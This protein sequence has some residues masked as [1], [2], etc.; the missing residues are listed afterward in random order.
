MNYLLVAKACSN[1]SFL[2]RLGA[3]SFWFHR[4]VHITRQT[5]DL[6][7]DAYFFEPGTEMAKKDPILIKNEIE[8]FLISPQYY[9]GDSHVSFGF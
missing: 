6:L 5:L 4:K 3:K 7:E 8:T 9:G 1:R 2:P